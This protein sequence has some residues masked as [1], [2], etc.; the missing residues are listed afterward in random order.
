MVVHPVHAET[1]LTRGLSD[2]GPDVL[3]GFGET[4]RAVLGH[5]RA[6][7]VVDVLGALPVREEW[8]EDHGSSSVHDE[9]D[10]ASEGAVAPLG[11]TGERLREYLVRERNVIHVFQ[12]WDGGSRGWVMC[13]SPRCCRMRHR[14]GHVHDG[15]DRNWNRWLDRDELGEGIE[16]YFG[17]GV[18]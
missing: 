4:E 7:D 18:E 15:H 5:E 12:S 16:R 6:V 8:V 10:L 1:E 14:H 13:C 9:A 11:E 17:L 2:E 3:L